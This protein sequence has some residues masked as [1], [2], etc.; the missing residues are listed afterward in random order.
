VTGILTL[1]IIVLG[2]LLFD[3]RRRLSGLERW[4]HMMREHAITSAPTPQKA[5]QEAAN[6]GVPGSF[7]ATIS[8]ESE[9]ETLP[10]P[11]PKQRPEAEPE[12]A[13]T[14]QARPVVMPQAAPPKIAAS[15]PI[16]AESQPG[17]ST[18]IKQ[19]K[20]GF[21]FEDLFG[22][23][24]PIWGGGLTLIVAA[25]LMVKY[26]ID[27]G[28]LSPAVRVALGLLFGVGLIGLSE[29][30]RHRETF[31]RDARV[32]QALA[33]AGIGAL[34]AA[35]L[36]AAN[37]YGLVGPG[38]AFAGLS[39]IT[40]LA[41]ALALRFGAP[42]AV[43]GLIGGLAAPALVQSQSPSVPLLAGYLALVIAAITM[44]SRRQ[45]WVWLGVSALV[46]GAGWSLVTIAVGGLDS[47]AT[48]S[49]GLL[50]V[51]LAFGLPALTLEGRAA[52][53]LRGAAAVVGALQVALLV[54]QGHFAPLTWG[55]YGL[56]SFAYVW[57]ADRTPV[58]RRSV[59]VPLL[60]ALGLVLAWPQPDLLHFSAV[61]A[62]IVLIY[63][64]YALR[65]L[66]REHGGLGETG[67]L[68]AIGI[69]GY[70]ACFGKFYDGAPGQDMRFALVALLFAALPAL[71]AAT[72]WG[73]EVRHKDARFA[74]L[75]AC[76]GALVVVAGL[77]GLPA[78]SAPIVIAAA[79]AALLGISSLA[80]DARLSLG[81]L[82]FLAAAVIALVVS[83]GAA[84]ELDRFVEAIPVPQLG[85]AL[86]R[87]TAVLLAALAFA[88]RRAGNRQRLA[89]QPLAV[90]LGYG[91]V[92]QLVPAPWL[93]VAA[94]GTLLLL[95]EAQG[96][97]S[98]SRL[99]PAQATLAGVLLLWALEPLARSMSAA[100]LSLVADPMLITDLS[101]PSTALRRL[102]VPASAAL[103]VL[104]RRRVRLSG[105]TRTAAVVLAA[106]AAT[107]GLHVLYKQLF[108]I[109]DTATFLRQGLVERCV[110][111]AM[112]VVAGFALWRLLGHHRAA[113]VV[114]MAA[115]AHNIVYTLI[116][117]NPLWAQQAV[118]AWPLANGLLP[119]YGLSFVVLA[120]ASQ[121]A[122]AGFAKLQRWADALRMAT[123][124]LFAFATLR[125]LFAG[126]IL[127][128]GAVG[129]AENILQSVLAI[130]LAIGFLAWGIRRS[131]RDWRIASL[132]LMLIAVG[133][134]FLF[135]ASGLEGLLRIA[136][137]LALGFSLIGIGWLYSRY[138]KPGTSQQQT[139]SV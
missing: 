96:R 40:G 125:Q 93:A 64:G 88:W 59:A 33:G 82:S 122:P 108:H 58:L 114:M 63:G 43:L 3:A 103:L 12:P 37:L 135:D 89:L 83:D 22:R 34:Y 85:H 74:A 14:P 53:M 24:L 25:V 113:L 1:A 56:L 102:V 2:T 128:H 118:G 6:S 19:P 60:T 28:L 7:H 78:W 94:A 65:Q 119:A 72:G 97:K 137:F 70:A 41:L 129:E 95:G 49:M 110:W 123:I 5:A 109:A 61:V 116:L 42:C 138:L 115:L 105:R 86:L 69:G 57:L 132:A 81:A 134:V 47:G 107:L 66:W 8:P 15:R 76:S 90:L 51:L 127:V 45:R 75:A 71:G 46:G 9:L 112:L 39:L 101:D 139:S 104:W 80:G 32:A 92:A 133:K 91:V 35:T 62:G 50:V 26:S 4:M 121:L 18:P 126:S 68:C 29:L 36:A 21:G 23:K 120:L 10:E 136:S 99:V 73:K 30:A 131:S 31:V 124:V 44:L 130:A 13:P 84:A 117:H 16:T 38:L 87:W 111:E 79:A 77:I 55:L 52:P 98:A 48:V 11:G 106:G 100:T 20:S 17:P 67:L 54:G 27:S